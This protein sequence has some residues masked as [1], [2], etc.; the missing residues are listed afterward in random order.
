MPPVLPVSL[1]ELHKLIMQHANDPATTEVDRRFEKFSTTSLNE[2]SQHYDQLKLHLI[3]EGDRGAE[4]LLRQR[5]QLLR[6]L[7]NTR[8]NPPTYRIPKKRPYI[9]YDRKNSYLG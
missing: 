4:T 8:N 5:H 1:A 6:R 9:P 7:M 2:L 3:E